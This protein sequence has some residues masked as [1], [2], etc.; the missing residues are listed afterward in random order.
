LASI[1][2]EQRFGAWVDALRAALAPGERFVAN[3]AG[4]STDFARLNRGKVRQAGSVEQDEL[5]I[6]LVRGARH[7][8]HTLQMSGNAADD[9]AAIA[10]AVAGLR[11]VLPDLADDPHLLL[12]TASKARARIAAACCRR[13]RP[14]STRCSPRRRASTSSGS[15]RP[16]RCG[17]ASRTARASAT[18]T[19]QRRS[20][21][22]GASTTAP[23]R[24]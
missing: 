21:S 3:L 8:E 7:A 17:A 2:A 19:W 12:P 1:A 22:S 10:D 11:A 6:R 14:S 15:T 9:R 13:P 18:G 20:T 16:V 24:R 23:T 4:E 5:A